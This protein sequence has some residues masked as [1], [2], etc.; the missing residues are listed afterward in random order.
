VS[1]LPPEVKR[2]L[3]DVD[4][5]ALDLARHRDFVIERVMTRGGLVAMRWLRAAVERDVLADFLQRKGQRLS[6]RDRAYWRLVCGLP[7]EPQARGGGRP[8][9]LG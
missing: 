2:L 7:E 6:P 4:P 1:P 8:P 5:D 9:W 3:W